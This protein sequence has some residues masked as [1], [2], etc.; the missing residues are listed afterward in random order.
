MNDKEL[1]DMSDLPKTLQFSQ[2]SHANGNKM[3]R[4]SYYYGPDYRYSDIVHK[5]NLAW[6]DTVLKAKAKLESDF[7][8]PLNSCLLNHYQKKGNMP[9]HQDN[10]ECLDTDP[11]IFSLSVGE[12]KHLVVKHVNEPQKTAQFQMCGGTLLI[13]MG[14]INRDW[15]HGVPAKCKDERLNLTFRLIKNDNHTLDTILSELRELKAEITMIKK[16][17]NEKEEKISH[18]QNQL[19]HKQK[20]I[21]QE[22]KKDV[23]ILKSQIRESSPEICSSHI[24]SCLSKDG[25]HASD[26]AYI[27]DHRPNK[28]PI[29]IRFKSVEAKV[30]A[31]K[32]SS[33]SIRVRIL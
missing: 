30:T 17:L 4:S 9:F 21:H 24:N 14:K 33:L 10:E 23:V 22:T 12:T 29:I 11:V 13:M 5:Q 28:G 19:T 1:K 18:L 3:A 7:L 27:Q 2:K 32:A 15:M 20:S 26:I 6:N 31:L 16:Q 25:V 8:Q